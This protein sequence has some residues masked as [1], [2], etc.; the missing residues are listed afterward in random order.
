MLREIIQVL[1]IVLFTIPVAALWAMGFLLLLRPVNILH[2]RWR[3]LV[4]IP[5]LAANLLAALENNLYSDAGFTVGWG[6]W[7]V[8]GIDLVLGMGLWLTSSGF[9]IFGLSAQEVEAAITAG[10]REVGMRVTSS[11]RE[12]LLFLGGREAV[13]QLHIEGDQNVDIRIRARLNEIIVQAES[14]VGRQLLRDLFPLLQGAKA[15]PTSN[16]RATGVLY[17]VLGLVFAVLGWIFF[18]EPRL[19][20]IE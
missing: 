18:F 3:L 8:L 17:L 13:S 5:L 6:F 20:L 15:N 4:L 2:R 10:C 14:T 12:E 9:L 19:I 7:L 11:Q 16:S 1:Q